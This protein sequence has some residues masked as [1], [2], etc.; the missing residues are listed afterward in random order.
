MS[1][2]PY[3][4]PV[5]VHMR[6]SEA[7]ISG[8]DVLAGRFTRLA[9]AMVDSVLM[10][11]IILPIQYLTGSFARTMSQQTGWL[12]Q[13]GMSLFGF[14]VMLALNGYLLLNRGQTIGKMLTG[15]QIV[16][17][18][19]GALLPFLRVFVYRYMWLVPLTVIVIFIPGAY[20]DQLVSLVALIDALLIFGSDRRCLHDYIAGSRVVLYR[21]D[22]PKHM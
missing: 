11:A 18:Q 22:R 14:L 15:I 8:G 19:S 4:P 9:A 5:M 21:A 7:A 12:E 16:G 13:V 17:V 2:N 6:E 1:N 10:M 3:A 20:D